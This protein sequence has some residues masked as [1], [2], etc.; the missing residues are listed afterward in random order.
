MRLRKALSCVLVSGL[1]ATIPFCVYASSEHAVPT[2]GTDYTQ[3]SQ[4]V[5]K[6][7]TGF[8][9]AKEAR[10]EDILAS[11]NEPHF[12]ATYSVKSD[13][14]EVAIADPWAGYVSSSS[15]YKWYDKSTDDVYTAYNA[16][17]VG[18]MY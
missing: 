11:E 3:I 18:Y 6:G 1:L 7:N 9:G 4:E 14:S 16:V 13:K 8:S 12:V 17:N 2:D 10:E 15:S 5:T